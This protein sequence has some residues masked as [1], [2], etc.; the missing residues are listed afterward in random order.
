MATTGLVEIYESALYEPR[1]SL[2]KVIPPRE[3]NFNLQSFM[4]ALEALDMADERVS[5]EIAAVRGKVE[6][7]VRSQRADNVITSLVSHYPN[8]VFEA[9]DRKDDPL[10]VEQETENAWRQV[11]WPGGDEWMPFQVYDERN[12]LEH[13]GDPFIDMI[14]GM[15]NELR[16]GS[17]VVSRLVLT[18]KDH[19]WSEDWRSRAMKGIGSENQMLADQM[20]KEERKSEKPSGSTSKDDSMDSEATMQLVYAIAALMGLGLIAYLA[21]TFVWPRLSEG[22]VWDIV[23]ACVVLAVAVVLVGLALFWLGIKTGV[24]KRKEAPRFQDPDLVRLRVEGAAFRME[25]QVFAILREDRAEDE[26][27]EQLIR[28]AVAAYRSFDN[29]LGCQFDAGPI[30]KLDGLTPDIENMDYVGG[31][32]S[33]NSIGEGVIG[34]REVAAFWHVP[35]ESAKVPGLN[36]AGSVRIPMPEPMFVMDHETRM[37]S[38][39]VGTEAY[40][41][42]GLRLAFL[43]PDVL[44][45]H[46]LYVGKTRSGKS[47]LMLHVGVGILLQ[48]V[49]KVSDSA[50]VVVDPH[51]DLANDIIMRMG[52][53]AGRFVR[54]IDMSDTER[55]CGINLLDVREFPNRDITIPTII[56]IAKSSSVN[57][58]DRMEAIMTW[59]FAT[60]FEAN[61][62]RK[63]LEQYT[64]FDAVPFLTKDNE[65]KK[66]IR[67]SKSK[68]IAEWWAHV[69]P[70]LAPKDDQTALAPV[71]RKITEY[72]SSPIARRVLGQRRCTISIEK[73]L[74]AGN[75]IIVNTARGEAGPEVSAIIGSCILN[76]TEFILREQSKIESGSRRP[77]T[78]IVDEMQ[79]FPGV[80][81]DNM[82]AE[83]NKYGGSLVMATQS[84][85]RLNEMGESGSMRETILSNLGCLAAFQVNAADSTL[86]KNELDSTALK[87]EDIMRLPPHN[88]YGRVN[89]DSGVEFF[90]IEVLKPFDPDPVIL[91][92]VREASEMYT[93][94]AE[95]VDAE[96]AR[97]MDSKIFDIFASEHEEEEK[98]P[99][100]DYDQ[101][102]GESDEDD[103]AADDDDE[104]E[105]DEDEAQA[106]GD[107]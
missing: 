72:A 45:R 77:V 2:V 65:R 71:L 104:G 48:K 100:S 7:F 9:V 31:A 78:V 51:S 73:E 56:S 1:E 35:G 98:N 90:S 60:L 41:D 22:S 79:T 63:P 105:S 69:F 27:I 42:G 91:R 70:T 44:K 64:I 74:A 34:T 14:A 96:H 6:M 3:G 43:P 68:E 103:S 54:L 82:L 85:D 55:A 102:V 4:N 28:P 67:E 76:L 84:L 17:R 13:G 39:L 49:I 94:P 75:A 12:P 18:Q 11:L 36:R 95:E 8:I 81:Y 37:R 59:T 87:E 58:G 33:K 25:V 46:H 32:K 24:F 47:T 53:D 57:W 80:R 16:P 66:I 86:L 97:S 52:V 30:E 88:C 15:S 23:L 50:L 107:S 93:T 38:V 29:P 62:H 21:M 26:A 40:R 99:T 61:R 19:N 89:L 106:S 83:L 10:Y 5:L 92:L 101:D 20:R